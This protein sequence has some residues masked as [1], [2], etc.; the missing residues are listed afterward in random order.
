MVYAHAWVRYPIYPCIPLLFLLYFWVWLVWPVQYQIIRRHVWSLLHYLLL[1]SCS[2]IGESLTRPPWFYCYFLLFLES[3]SGH[4]DAVKCAD[5]DWDGRVGAHIWFF[6][7][8]LC[9]AFCLAFVF[10]SPKFMVFFVEFEFI[11][12]GSW[13]VVSWSWSHTR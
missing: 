2:T 1:A 9:E 3:S 12:Y 4:A 5:I 6:L 10:L 7:L 8:S 11:S 13:I